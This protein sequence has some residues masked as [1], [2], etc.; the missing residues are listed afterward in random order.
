MGFT[1]VFVL[2]LNHPGNSSMQNIDDEPPWRQIFCRPFEHLTDYQKKNPCD[3]FSELQILRRLCLQTDRDRPPWSTIKSVSSWD[4][5]AC[6]VCF[7][8][9][10]VMH[11]ASVVQWMRLFYHCISE[12]CVFIHR[13]RGV[14][15]KANDPIAVVLWAIDFI[16]RKNHKLTLVC[17]RFANFLFLWQP[18]YC[19]TFSSAWLF[20]LM[21]R[22][23]K[24]TFIPWIWNNP[25]LLLMPRPLFLWTMRTQ[26]SRLVLPVMANNALRVCRRTK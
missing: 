26:V 23:N 9:A 3:E 13:G 14:Q 10:F 19:E 4:R 22:S 12:L 20:I 21:D 2:Y 18:F 5:T 8:F 11:W 24:I 6:F 25:T 16:P 15:I 7:R 17:K 1:G